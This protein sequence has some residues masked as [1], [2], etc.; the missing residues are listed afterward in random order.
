VAPECTHVHD[1]IER[2][3]GAD[4]ELCSRH[5]V[6]DRRRNQYNRNAELLELVSRLRKHQ[7]AVVSLHVTQCRRSREGSANFPVFRKQMDNFGDVGDGGQ[8]P[9]PI[10]LA[11]RLYSRLN[12]CTRRDKNATP[13]TATRL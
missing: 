13:I 5:V 11:G 8:L 1:L 12:C 2:R 4:A 7:C 6:V 9:F 3:I 10:S